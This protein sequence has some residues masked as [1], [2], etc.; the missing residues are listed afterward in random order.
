[1][2]ENLTYTAEYHDEEPGERLAEWVVVKWNGPAVN[3]VRTGGK[4]RSFGYDEMAAKMYANNLN[5][6]EAL[7]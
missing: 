3:G 2:L 1:M 4:V 6:L 5:A 7:K